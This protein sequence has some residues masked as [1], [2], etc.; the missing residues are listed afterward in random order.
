MKKATKGGWHPSNPNFNGINLDK[1]IHNGWDAAHRIYSNNLES[2]LDNNLDEIST[3]SEAKQF[4]ND[5]QNHIKQQLQNGKKLN[6]VV[7]D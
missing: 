4:L 3:S 5:L 6:E 1:S 7:F 2:F